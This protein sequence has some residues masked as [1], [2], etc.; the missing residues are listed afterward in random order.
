MGK[1]RKF[2]W[3]Y[4]LN[5]HVPA[6]PLSRNVVMFKV[7]RQMNE[8]LGSLLLKTEQ[9]NYKKLNIPREANYTRLVRKLLG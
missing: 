4:M 2:H 1:M 8:K 9:K 6:H 5:V 3:Q 7:W